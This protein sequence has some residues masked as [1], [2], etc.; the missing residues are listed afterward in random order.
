MLPYRWN[1]NFPKTGLNAEATG[2]TCSFRSN[3][4]L[5][6]VK[7]FTAAVRPYCLFFFLLNT[8]PP[9]RRSYNTKFKMPAVKYAL[10][11]GNRTAERQFDPLWKKDIPMWTDHVL[12][13]R[14]VKLMADHY[15]NS[16]LVFPWLGYNFGSTI[17]FPKYWKFQITG[18][19]GRPVSCVW[20]NNLAHSYTL[21]LLNGTK[22]Y[23][24]VIHPQVHIISGDWNIPQHALV[25]CTLF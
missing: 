5:E 14:T 18:F 3:H 24:L 21:N 10:E 25:S 9:A 22:R 17:H 1:N 13:T 12:E 20:Q 15:A 11:N 19:R 6:S 8:L 2:S 4:I 16:S 7:F 23:E